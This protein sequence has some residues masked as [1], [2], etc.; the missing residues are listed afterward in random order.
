MSATVHLENVTISYDR[1]PAVHHVSGTFS[2]GSL[3]AVA[4]PNG[5]GKSTLIKGIAGILSPDHGHITV[6]EA[7]ARIAYLPQA[8]EMQRDFPLSVLEM[9]TTGLWQ[10]AGRF[11][12]IT[13]TMQHKAT[14]AIEAVGLRG[15]E[16]RTL[17]TLSTGQFQRA[18][19]ARLLLQDADLILLDEPFAAI[20]ED[21]TRHLINIIH[22]W[23]SEQRTIICVLHDVAQIKQYFP[24]CLLLARECVAWDTS[25]SALHP[26]R[27][28]NAR[29]FQPSWKVDAERC[30]Q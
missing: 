22:R 23:H 20:D 4:G 15:F 18:L 25:E 12:R 1:H 10:Q 19:F 21:T 27:L 17:D 3:T 5:A 16:H 13:R 11:G 26:E 30:E 8:A 9:V 24:Q 29:F 7:G 6:T 28:L 2:P 14:E